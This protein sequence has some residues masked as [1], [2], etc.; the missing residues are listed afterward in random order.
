MGRMEVKAMKE[1]SKEQV[2]RIFTDGSGKSLGG[3]VSGFAWVREDTGKYHIERIPDLT[4]NEAE[5]HGVISALK[6]LHPGTHVEVLTDSLLVV[7]QLRGEYRTLDP[8]LLKLAAEVRT[9]AEQKR[10]VLTLKW[11]PRRENRAG[12]L[13]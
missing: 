10:L 1:K 4:N 9:I 11:V 8:K 13:L 7:S 6:P 5:Y 3:G 12:K 2:V